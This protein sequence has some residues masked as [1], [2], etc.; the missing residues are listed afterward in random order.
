MFFKS[1]QQQQY[2]LQWVRKTALQYGHV[3]LSL[4]LPVLQK[5]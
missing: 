5:E 4:G 1:K 3:E 2:N